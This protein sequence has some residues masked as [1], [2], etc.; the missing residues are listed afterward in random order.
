M[1]REITKAELVTNKD[2]S[3]EMHIHFNGM[4]V[5]NPINLTNE[6]M[7]LLEGIR[8]TTTGRNLLC[9]LFNLINKIEL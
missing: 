7:E 4:Y 5:S 1:K 9:K 8:N 2:N 3:Q 6:E